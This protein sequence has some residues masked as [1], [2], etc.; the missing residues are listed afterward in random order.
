MLV[1]F[2]YWKN[3]ASRK[4]LY[5]ASG[6]S[7][8]KSNSLHLPDRMKGKA[9]PITYTMSHSFHEFIPDIMFLILCS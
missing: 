9:F 2:Q 3:Q 7:T 8:S 1:S 6:F 4:R 5:T